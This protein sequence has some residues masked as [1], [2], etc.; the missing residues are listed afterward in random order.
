MHEYCLIGFNDRVQRTTTYNLSSPNI[1]SWELEDHYLIVNWQHPAD[2]N[3]HVNGYYV[4]LCKLANSL[5]IGPDFVNFKSYVR[6]GRIVGLA[7]EQTY[8]MEVSK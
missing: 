4:S 5:C 2:S 8:Q 7:P 6:S 3:Q 1:T